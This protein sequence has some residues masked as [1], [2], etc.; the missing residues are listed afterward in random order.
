MIAFSMPLFILVVHAAAQVMGSNNFTIVNGLVFTPGLAIV[1]APQPYTPVGGDTLQ[2]AIDVSGDGKL[3][4]PPSTQSPTSPTLFHSITIFLT[5]YTTLRNFT[6]SNGSDIPA[7]SMAFVGPVLSLEPSSTVKHINWVW[8]ACLVGS[9]SDSSSSS[10]GAYNISLHQSFRWNG[11]EYYTIFDLPISVTN[12]IP[13]TSSSG[14]VRADCALVENPL[15]DAAQIINSS[16]PLPGSPWII[17]N[18]SSST[19][20]T[21]TSPGSGGVSI[22]GTGSTGGRGSLTT[23]PKSGSWA[24]RVGNRDSF[25]LIIS[26]IILLFLV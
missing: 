12:S 11:T 8:P 26:S 10:R 6:I 13:A 25:I 20:G 18:S 15:L 17:G 23:L 24:L 21:L 7:G 9:G 4:W 2:I 19:G 22:D 3:P 14:Q 16:D 1:D 5:S